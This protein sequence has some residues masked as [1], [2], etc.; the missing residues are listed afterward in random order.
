M[1]VIKSASLLVLFSLLHG[2]IQYPTEMVVED[3]QVWATM[4]Y[5]PTPERD[6]KFLFS[7]PLYAK[8]TLL[9]YYSATA[10]RFPIPSRTLVNSRA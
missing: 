6:K 5:M 2:C 7:D 8:R 9:F 3:Q 10:V 4:P 1:D